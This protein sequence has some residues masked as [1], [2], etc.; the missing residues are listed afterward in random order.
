MVQRERITISRLELSNRTFPRDAHIT[1]S[2][3]AVQNCSQSPP[4]VPKHLTCGYC[5][6]GAEYEISFSINEFKFEWPH[7]ISTQAAIL[8][9]TCSSQLQPFLLFL[10]RLEW[11][12]AQ[13]LGPHTEPQPCR[14]LAL[15]P[16]QV[17]ETL[18]T[19]ASS[20]VNWGMTRAAISGGPCEE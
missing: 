18:C 15:S 19:S 13:T 9:F 8:E 17:F 11:W 12:T 16:C 7:G 5:D 14:W 2:I 3:C 10:C 1:S 20:C 4:V 6:L